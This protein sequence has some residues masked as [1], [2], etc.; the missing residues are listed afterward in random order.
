MTNGSK[1]ETRVVQKS[2]RE[3]LG[4]ANTG[5]ATFDAR[6][7]LPEV[8][9]A[10]IGQLQFLEIPPNAFDGIGGP[11]RSLGAFPPGASGADC[12]DSPSSADSDVR[13]GH[14]RSR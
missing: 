14:P 6:H 12:A 4:A 13:A 3:D 10:A 9:H 7:S 2:E 1:R 8:V 5:H 11:A